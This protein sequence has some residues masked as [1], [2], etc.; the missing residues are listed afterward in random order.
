MKFTIEETTISIETPFKSPPKPGDLILQGDTEWVVT[1]TNGQK[2]A[3]SPQ[4]PE[5]MLINPK[6]DVHKWPIGHASRVTRTGDHYVIIADIH[7][8]EGDWIFQKGNPF[9]IQ[10]ASSSTYVIAP[11]Y[12]HHVPESGDFYYVE[13]G[14]FPCV[15][16]NVYRIEGR[17]VIA[18]TKPFTTSP[19]DWCLSQN[20]RHWGMVSCFSWSA[21]P[22]IRFYE[23]KP[24]P[25]NP[26]PSP[27]R[28]G[29]IT[30]HV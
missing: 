2:L 26:D 19:F 16:K 9:A 24:H 18:M 6:F 14:A 30:Y 27:P 11:I 23:V 17:N 25:D 13:D 20:G 28:V 10:E 1:D 29:P 12:P 15:V 7:M 21:I 5:A 8:E 3:I 22:R 4:Q